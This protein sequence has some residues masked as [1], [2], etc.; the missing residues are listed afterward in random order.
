MAC[1]AMSYKDILVNVDA[2]KG[3]QAA[4]GAAV[5]IAA[6]HAAH[7]TA[8]H[9]T[10]PP[11]ASAELGPGAMT[12]MIRW[13][14]EHERDAAR[15]AEAAVVAAR[16]RTEVP[17]EWRLA[18]GDVVPALASHAGYADLV[19]VARGG[20][21]DDSAPAGHLAG[22]IAMSS[23]RPVLVVP[24]TGAPALTGERVLVA[25]NRSREASRAIHDAL[26]ILKRAK[27]VIVLE[28]KPASDSSSRLAG[29]DIARHL[30]H[31]GIAVS[32]ETAVAGGA[33]VGGIVW[34]RAADIS[35]DLIVAG[36]YGHSRLREFVFGGVTRELLTAA[37][38]PVLIAH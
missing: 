10:P 15:V 17:V 4:L 38:M 33:A 19:V 16:Q 8:L 6:A 1:W 25:W 29:A 13:Q 20:G 7:V 27:S 9:V 26:P 30:A 2:T 34:R 32:A 3:S 35:A 28:V 11:F 5:A 37:T 23:G 22:A 36:A 21:D 18:P 24:N 14:Q 31:H 12:E